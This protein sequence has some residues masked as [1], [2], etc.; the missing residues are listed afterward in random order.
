MQEEL[1]ADAGDFYRILEGHKDALARAVFRRHLQQIF[2]VKFDRAV[3]HLIIFASCQRRRK[4]TFPGTVRP[5]DGVDFARLDVK[6]EATQDGFIFYA[7]L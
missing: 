1:V 7:D 6:I 3:G 4:R 2:A 5:H